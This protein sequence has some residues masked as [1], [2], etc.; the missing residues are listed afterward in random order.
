MGTHCGLVAPNGN[1]V[2]DLDELWND[3]HWISFYGLSMTSFRESALSWKTSKA[4][5]CATKK[6]WMG[7][8]FD[9]NAFVFIFSHISVIIMQKHI[10]WSLGSAFPPL[11]FSLC[12]TIVACAPLKSLKCTRACVKKYLFSQILHLEVFI[13]TYALYVIKLLIDIL[14][15]SAHWKCQHY[16][17]TF[18]AELIPIILSAT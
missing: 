9:G 12:Y 17:F 16:L 1:I 18:D 10:C 7:F 4:G 6:F 14:K 5:I 13:M 15:F 11:T 2:L 8:E 3:I